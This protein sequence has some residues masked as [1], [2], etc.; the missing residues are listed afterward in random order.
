MCRKE[1][2]MFNKV[3][4]LIRVLL[5]LNFVKSLMLTWSGR[6]ISVVREQN[7]IARQKAFHYQK[8]VEQGSMEVGSGKSI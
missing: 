8:Q 6:R 7:M 4:D 3:E 5:K 2:T 1:E